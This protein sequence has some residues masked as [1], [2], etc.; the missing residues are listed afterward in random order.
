MLFASDQCTESYRRMCDGGGA[1]NVSIS[2][3]C[4]L[5]GIGLV[6]PSYWSRNGLIGYTFL[7]STY[8]V[9]TLESN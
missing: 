1:N 3:A 8:F 9:N 6:G 2:R 5:V 7:G 4:M